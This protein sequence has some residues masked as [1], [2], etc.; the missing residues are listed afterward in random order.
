VFLIAIRRF[1]AVK[2]KEKK[3]GK[4]TSEERRPRSAL[5]G[6]KTNVVLAYKEN[7]RDESEFR[8]HV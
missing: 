2:L 8:S 4:K 7:R 5:M 1:R 6:M 3:R